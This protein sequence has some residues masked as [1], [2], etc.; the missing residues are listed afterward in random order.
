[1]RR[2]LSYLAN[3]TTG[4]IILWCYGIWYAVNVV[5]HFDARP[6]LWVTSIG[7]AAIIGFALLISTRSSSRGT[8]Q[9]D[10]WQIFRLF[11]M[12]F[13]VSS[14][15]ALVKDAGFLLIF[16]PN[17]RENLVGLALI[18]GFVVLINVLK[19]TPLA[20]SRQSGGAK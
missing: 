6:R 11:L 19:R 18:A 17:L 20:V 13:C 2:L 5:N 9:L 10:G 12:P 14:F 15:A 3:L 16:P 7:L 8:T 1:M 4:R